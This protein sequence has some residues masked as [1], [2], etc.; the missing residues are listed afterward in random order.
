MY[1][2]SYVDM[3]KRVDPLRKELKDLETKAEDTRQKGEEITKII[4]ELEASIAK[5]KEEYA[6]VISDAS[7]IKNDL[8]TFEKKFLLRLRHLEKSLLTALNEVKGRILDNNR[9]ITELETLK[10]EAGEVQRKM[11]E[12]D[13]VEVDRVSQQYLPLSTSCSA[14]YFTLESLNQLSYADM[15]KRVDPLR[16][17]L[18]DLETKAEDTHQKGE[19]ITKIIAELE[20]SIA[21]YKE[22]YAMLISDANVIK[23]DLSTVEKKGKVF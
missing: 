15:L 3:L 22:D 20:A 10:E 4:A 21:K 17:E 8:S 18:K 2:L 16:K 11:E 14:M 1:K 6:M 5:Y 23:N 12:T 13:T 7:V 19:E 9:I